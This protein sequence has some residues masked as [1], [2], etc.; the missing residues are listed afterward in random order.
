MCPLDAEL[1]ERETGRHV[2]AFMSTTHQDPDML[3]ELFILEP[4]EELE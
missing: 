1:I 3:A 2:E 4:L